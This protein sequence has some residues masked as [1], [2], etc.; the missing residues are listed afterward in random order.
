MS[1]EDDREGSYATGGFDGTLEPGARPAL[2]I[3]DP[4]RAYAD[5][6]CGLY[7]GESVL[8]VVES[9]RSLLAAARAAEIP[10]IVTE[11][12][13]RPDL[14]DAGVFGRKVPALEA[15]TRGNPFGEFVDGLEP[16]DGELRLT[17]Q[18][19]SAYFGT[20]LAANLTSLKV[21]TVLIAGFSTSGC[22]R[23]SALDTMQYG[24]VPI[25]VADAVG[26][27]VRAIHDANLFDIGAKTGE[28]WSLRRAEAYLAETARISL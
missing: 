23:A 19:P 2:L 11:V 8:P 14:A 20:P 16:A 18:Y 7:V 3:V 27:R 12:V 4:A 13:L 10:V 5:P 6:E 17:K 21:D 9:M 26:D 28:V 24:F 15:F 1:W 22:V 25:V